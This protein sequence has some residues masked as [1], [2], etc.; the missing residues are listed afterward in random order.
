MDWKRAKAAEEK[1]PYKS[2]FLPFIYGR[3]IRSVVWHS[4]NELKRT[5]EAIAVCGNMT[6]EKNV[7]R[8]S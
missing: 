3:E 4:I 7:K 5:L 2:V 1:K 8:R 6:R